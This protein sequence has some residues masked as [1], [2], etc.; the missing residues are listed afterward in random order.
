MGIEESSQTPYLVMEFVEGLPLDRI[1]EKGTI[2]MAR[3]CAWWPKQQKRSASL[4]I[5]A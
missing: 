3:A 4:T 5:A 2:P 1:L